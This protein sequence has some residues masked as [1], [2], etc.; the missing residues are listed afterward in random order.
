MPAITIDMLFIVKCV[1][2]DYEWYIVQ[3]VYEDFVSFALLGIHN[4]MWCVC[5]WWCVF[6]VMCMYVLL[7]Y[8]VMYVVM[9]LV[10]KLFVYHRRTHLG[11][12]RKHH[13]LS[14][15]EPRVVKADEV[16]KSLVYHIN[17]AQDISYDLRYILL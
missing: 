4:A 16:S 9:W 7:L 12:D 11:S 3:P 5:V 17:V 2:Q 1:G 13:D 15:M 10:I 6:V 14:I 8:V